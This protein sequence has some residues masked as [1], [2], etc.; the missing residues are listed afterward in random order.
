MLNVGED[1][2]GYGERSEPKIFFG[3]PHWRGP[4]FLVPSN[5]G[6]HIFLAPSTFFDSERNRNRPLGVK[7]ARRMRNVF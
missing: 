7:K 3:P 1:G 2:I 4:T 6:D 5:G